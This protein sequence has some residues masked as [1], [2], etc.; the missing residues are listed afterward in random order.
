MYFSAAAS[1]E[2]D[3]GSMMPGTKACWTTP[4]L[5]LPPFWLQ[6]SATRTHPALGGGVTTSMRP[7]QD[8]LRFEPHRPTCA[9]ACTL[10]RRWS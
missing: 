2:K 5:V 7:S 9:L 6:K 10:Q 1:S 8:Q 4:V 3:H